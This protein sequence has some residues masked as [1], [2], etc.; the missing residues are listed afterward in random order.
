MGF[1][2]PGTIEQL[3][4][5]PLMAGSSASTPRAPPSS[6][7]SS[8]IGIDS[9]EEQSWDDWQDEQPTL[10]K[11]LFSVE[12]FD[13]ATSALQ[14]DRQHFGVDVPL[15]ASTLDFFERIRLIN[16][17]RA[18]KPEPSS[19][20]R[21]DRNADFLQDDQY[22]KPVLQDDAL[23][24]YD[25]DQLSLADEAPSTSE[26][27]SYTV[28]SIAGLNDSKLPTTST[29]PTNRDTAELI[30]NLRAQLYD[31][32]Q[33]I[34]TL[35]GII[36]ER[37]GPSMGLDSIAL[38]EEAG[39]G[40]K[41]VPDTGADPQRDDDTHYFDSYAYNDIHE[42]MLKDKVRTDSYRD[43]IMSNPQLFKDAV[44]LDV[45]CGTGILSMF[46]AKSGAKK[47]YAVDASNVV[48][49]AQ[50]SI[51]A[52][53]LSEVITVIR[54]KI[55]DLE[56]PEKVDIIVSEWMGY[57]LLYECM[58]DSVLSARDRFMKPTGLMVPSQTSIM[59]AL[60]SGSAMVDDRVKFWDNVYGFDMSAM[61]EEI[62]D[63]A[64]IDVVDGKEVVSD[65]IA[66]SDIVTQTT[67]VADLSFTSPFKLTANRSTTVN[68]FLAHFDTFFTSDARLMHSQSEL[69]QG[70]VYFTTGAHDTPTHWKQTMF[71]LKEPIR[72]EAGTVIEG[73]FKC[74][75]N[76]ENSRELVV[77]VT[78]T[79][80]AKAE[81]PK[82][83]VKAQVW[84]VR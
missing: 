41:S 65:T 7:G 54:G 20:K 23:L 30:D 81:K 56:I 60:F 75:K 12:Q 66:I 57:C 59:L 61:K 8:S 19:L 6:S 13:S 67:T 80:H 28:Q 43:F 24:Q 82:R 38:E 22:L 72:V 71:L 4:S 1:H 17:I 5:D 78:W 42:V 2:F 47:V 44:V 33:A 16:W 62:K 51:K 58:L 77:E 70:E 64:L 36:R 34:D 74:S 26:Q 9:S 35:K 55:E 10:T 27:P 63:D 69:K 11:S 46:A 32:S 3:A 83:S 31:S 37:L 68:A 50:R 76:P 21:L 84:R 25:F 14:H 79:V 18:T 40:S 52:N 49:K 15:L 48:Y 39:K 53:G 29:G 45:G 73:S